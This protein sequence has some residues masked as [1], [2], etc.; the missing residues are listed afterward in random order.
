MKGLKVQQ[1]NS[2][3]DRRYD[4]DLA[5]QIGIPVGVG[6]ISFAVGWGIRQNQVIVNKENIK[7]L[8]DNWDDLRG[9]KTGGA[10]LFINRSECSEISKDLKNEI[11]KVKKSVEE[12]AKELNKVQ[13]FARWFLIEKE[14][15]SLKEVNEVLNGGG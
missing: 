11:C 9:S 7:K 12:Q 6:L 4:L 15:M 14:G 13:N 2:S 5:I 3:K 10:P 8:W 1:F